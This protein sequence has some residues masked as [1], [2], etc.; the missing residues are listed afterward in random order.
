MTTVQAN[1]LL[2]N[3]L[4]TE[5]VD[6]YQSINNAVQ[7]S[8]LSL[9]MNLDVKATNRIHEFAYLNQA[10]HMS[11]W[12]RGDTVPTD[13]MDSVGFTA[14]AHTWARRIPWH[15]EDRKD[16]QTNSLF[17]MARSAGSSAALLPAR[18]AFDALNGTADTL[19]SIQNAPDGVG[20]FSAVD[21]AGGARF[22]VSGG[23][24]VSGGAT[25]WDSTANVIAG[26]YGAIERFKGMQDGKGQ[27]LW[28]DDVLDQ[29][30]LIIHPHTRTQEMEEAFLQRRQGSAAGGAP[31]N[32][33][34][35]ASRDFTMWGSQRLSA[36]HI[37]VV[38]KGSPKKPLFLLDREGLQEMSSLEGDNNGDHTRDTGE[39]YVQFERRAGLG[40]ALPYGIVE[41]QD[42]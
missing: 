20:L 37:M 39:E 15:K 9:L 42:S 23:N 32:V 16:D 33:F 26:V 14:T 25:L 6:T 40:I 10:P 28:T 21:G 41:V 7:N 18:F 8:E 19:P 36:D 22:G 11:L 35:D 3:G 17:D 31:S 1:E 34:Q 5:F 2:A 38:A 30:F 29:G 13:M 24:I 4:R 27:P 12:R